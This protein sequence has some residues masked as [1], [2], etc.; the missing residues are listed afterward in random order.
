MRKIMTLLKAIKK[1]QKK[2]G[3]TKTLTC[4]YQW[5]SISI[6]PTVGG[7]GWKQPR[8]LKNCLSCKGILSCASTSHSAQ[9]SHAAIT[10][11]NNSNLL[12]QVAKSRVTFHNNQSLHNLA[13]YTTS[14]L[15]ELPHSR[16]PNW[17]SDFI[18]RIAEQLWPGT[19]FRT[20]TLFH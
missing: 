3:Q 15:W 19:G 4:H 2:K 10:T 14:I 6:L 11:T 12:T 20:L 1:Y 17:L 5:C 18:N 9:T 16:M 8:G 7:I 13:S